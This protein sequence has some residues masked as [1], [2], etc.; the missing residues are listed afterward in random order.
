M[1]GER[2]RLEGLGHVVDLTRSGLLVALIGDELLTWPHR[3]RLN[4]VA[5]VESTYCFCLLY[6]EILTAIAPDPAVS[7]SVDVQASLPNTVLLDKHQQ[8]FES[9]LG[10]PVGKPPSDKDLKRKISLGAPADFD[11]AIV[12]C[13][14]LAELYGW[15]GLQED[16]IPFTEV[17]KDG[18]RA[19]SE[20]LLSQVR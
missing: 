2:W 15:T 14:I 18:Q 7:L 10:R 5:L 9:S 8:I 4:S 11:P 19:V 1:R 16:R 17:R 3:E 13:K 6:K 20:K 12:S